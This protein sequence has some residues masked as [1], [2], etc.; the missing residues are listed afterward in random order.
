MIIYWKPFGGKRD[1]R[2][3]KIKRAVLEDK[4]GLEV[5]D[6]PCLLG[7]LGCVG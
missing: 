4:V 1:P 5:Q 3:L 7:E 6:H 2:D